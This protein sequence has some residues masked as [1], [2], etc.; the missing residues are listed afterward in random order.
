[1]SFAQKELIKMKIFETSKCSGQ[2]LA[3]SICQFWNNDSIPLQ[4]LYPSSFSWKIIP[5]YFFNLNNIY[6]A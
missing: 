1:M 4:I 3:N 5:L 2:I 6:F